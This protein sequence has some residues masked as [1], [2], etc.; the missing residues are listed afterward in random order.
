MPCERLRIERLSYHG[1]L[2]I[3]EQFD[4]IFVLDSSRSPLTTKPNSLAYF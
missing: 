1:S 4:A 2:W 3:V